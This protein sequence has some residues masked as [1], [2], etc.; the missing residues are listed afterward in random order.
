[1]ATL[2][3]GRAWIP[4]VRDCPLELLPKLLD[5]NPHGLS[6]LEVDG[7]GLSQPDARWSTGGDDVAW[8]QRHELTDIADKIGW[9]EDHG[10]RAAVLVPVPVHFQPHLEIRRV[11]HLIGS[12]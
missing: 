11:L 10:C 1:M 9:A 8:L 3:L 12:D 4:I 5:T 6:W 7:R 2:R